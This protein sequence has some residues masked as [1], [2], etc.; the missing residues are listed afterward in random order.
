MWFLEIGTFFTTLW[1][2][3]YYQGLI[4]FALKWIVITLQNSWWA[5]T[6][7]QEVISTCRTNLN[8]IA[9]WL[10]LYNEVIQKRRVVVTDISEELFL[11]HFFF[12]GKPAR[13]L[14]EKKNLQFEETPEVYLKLGREAFIITQ[15]S[16]IPYIIDL[17]NHPGCDYV[18]NKE[19]R[20]ETLRICLEWNCTGSSR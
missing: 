19:S 15:P 1:F 6:N 9:G 3:F 12:K 14:V 11:V 13:I 8:D 2:L 20:K 5:I 16:G 18:I 4:R 17:T 10:N 7:I